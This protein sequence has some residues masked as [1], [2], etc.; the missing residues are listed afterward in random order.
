M[1]YHFK[2]NNP[3]LSPTH[4]LGGC[5]SSAKAKNGISMLP[6]SKPPALGPLLLLLLVPLLLV[7]L[8]LSPSCFRL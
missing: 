1:N 5:C 4:T 3:L 2:M 6:A 7:P 8:L